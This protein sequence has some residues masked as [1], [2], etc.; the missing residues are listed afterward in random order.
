V[1]TNDMSRWA[2]T[3]MGNAIAKRVGLEKAPVRVEDSVEKL[4]KIVS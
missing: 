1:H 3:D 4:L 2:Q